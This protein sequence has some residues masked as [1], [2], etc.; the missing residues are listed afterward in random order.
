MTPTYFTLTIS[1]MN[2]EVFNKEL[3]N[4]NRWFQVNKLSVN[5]KKTNYMLL[6]TKKNTK[7][8][9]NLQLYLNSDRH[10]TVR[11]PL[12]KV[13]STKFLGLQIDQNITWKE[14]IDNIVKTCSRNV[15]IINKLKNFLPHEALYTLYCSLILPYINYGILAWGCAC[16]SYINDLFKIQKRALRIISAS[17]YRSSTN[18]LLIRYNT[19]SVRDMYTFE[20]GLFMYKHDNGLLPSVFDDL[21]IKQSKIHDLNTRNKDRLRLPFIKRA[22]CEKSIKYA[23]TKLWNNVDNSIKSSSSINQFRHVFKKHL[24]QSYY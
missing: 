8:E 10:S 4:V 6:G 11:T 16:S 18:P 17:D 20:L 1:L 14:H 21:F 24:M 15:G 2:I 9:Y 7:P 23:G 3:V 5:A 19:L 13:P 22:F 12:E